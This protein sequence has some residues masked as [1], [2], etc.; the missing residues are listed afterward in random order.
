MG[1]RVWWAE[2]AL[3]LPL[4]SWWDQELV[5]AGPRQGCVPRAPARAEWGRSGGLVGDR[6]VAI[7]IGPL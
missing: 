1:A 6:A 2:L 7:G 5:G 4:P 3:W